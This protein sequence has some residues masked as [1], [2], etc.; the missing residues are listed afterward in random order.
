M[1][2]LKEP[3]HSDILIELLELR[4]VMSAA[5]VSSKGEV[6]ESRSADAHDLTPLH[7]PLSS[8]FTSS[9][10]LA[11]LLGADAPSQTVLA[12]ASGKRLLTRRIETPSQTFS[13]VALTS[14]AEVD[15]VSFSLRL[16]TPQLTG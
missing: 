4:G 7:S 13:V 2:A 3:S 9:R 5:I 6:L 8:L 16:L 12:F 1:N 10:V 15:R 14:A 11:E